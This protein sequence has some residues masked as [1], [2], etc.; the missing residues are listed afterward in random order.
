M[1]INTV[2]YFAPGRR[3]KYCDDRVCM[4]VCL[5][6]RTSQK[7]KSKLTKFSE[8]YLHEIVARFSS[9]DNT[10]CY[11]LLVLWMMS[12]LPIMRL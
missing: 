8:R 7:T 12:C 9:D 10:I 2:Y 11:S 3:A 5:S 6:A 4:S 1:E